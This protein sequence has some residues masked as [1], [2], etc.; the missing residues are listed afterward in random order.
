MGETTADNNKTDDTKE[1]RILFDDTMLKKYK[2]VYFARYP[3]RKKFDLRATGMSLN[4]FTAKTRMAQAQAKAKYGEFVEYVLENQ[5]VPR[6]KLSKCH[7][8]VIF[9]WKNNLR[10]D[11]DNYAITLKFYMDKIVEYGLISD[12]SFHIIEE[13]E[14]RMEN[15]K[16]LAG[17]QVE[18][19]FM[20]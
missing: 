14:M 8:C 19:I 13:L 11:Y 5:N 18:F 9:R 17:H 1:V 10:R 20:Y 7:L 15:D 3:K 12:D 4:E 2:D 16:S 6:L